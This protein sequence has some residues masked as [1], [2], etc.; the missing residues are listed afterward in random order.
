VGLA[1][2]GKKARVEKPGDIWI[3][4]PLPG[5]ATTVDL[6]EQLEALSAEADGNLLVL[7]GVWVQR[8]D[9][10]G[11]AYIELM[12]VTSTLVRCMVARGCPVGAAT[13]LPCVS[14]CPVVPGSNLHW[15]EDWI[16]CDSLRAAGEHRCSAH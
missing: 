6:S 10:R 16:S 8:R 9:G 12:V 3:V 4:T 2:A 13:Y 1:Q 7:V 14:N 15:D 5:T 11:E